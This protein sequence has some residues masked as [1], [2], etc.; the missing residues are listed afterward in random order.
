M[1]KHLWTAKHT[2]FTND[3]LCNIYTFYIYVLLGKKKY[4]KIYLFVCLCYNI[5]LLVD[6]TFVLFAFENIYS[7]G[8]NKLIDSSCWGLNSNQIQLIHTIQFNAV[9]IHYINAHGSTSNKFE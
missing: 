3:Y 5:I 9:I 2:D 4:V 1:H 8:F 6:F 7:N